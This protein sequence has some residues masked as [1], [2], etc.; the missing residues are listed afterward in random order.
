MLGPMWP[1]NIVV[2]GAGIFGVTAAD[3]LA[4][5]G[6]RLTLLERGHVPDPRAASTDL[7]RIIRMDAGRDTT[8]ASLADSCVT[9][10][11]SSAA[12][13]G[14]PVYHADG[15][16]VLSRR[17]PTPGGFVQESIRTLERMGRAVRRLDRA[18]LARSFPAWARAD[19]ADGY[20]NPRGGWVEAGAALAAW[21][22][23]AVGA[24]V[25]LREESTV[26]GLWERGGAVRGVVLASGERL[27]ADRVLITA[28]SETARLV[29][30][31]SSRLDS[32]GQ[33]VFH[34]MPVD[35]T[36]FHSRAFPPWALDIGEA[37]WYGLP[38][39]RHGVLKIAHH[40]AGVA[41]DPDD[42][43]TVPASCVER[44]RSFLESH[45]PVLNGARI[46][47]QRLC[48][49]TETTDGDFLID[50]DPEHPGLVI[51]TGGGGHGF[52]FAPQLGQIA[53][54]VIDGRPNPW[55][56]RFAWRRPA[57]GLGAARTPAP[58]A[59]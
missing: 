23:R 36:P 30:W 49:T 3:V 44:L 55:R 2:V 47:A 48:Q 4:R 18:T 39:N 1:L 6:H 41:M 37:G 56:E 26:A 5:R 51:S 58:S 34:L 46:A 10:W 35:G 50:A 29:P 40:G 33:P 42:R 9:D 7:G 28:G 59:P 57:A 22:R 31:T 19:F 25:R 17:G 45:L 14:E 13:L 52:K 32:V 8:C 16:L 15:F 12:W 20:F 27:E 53:A 38:L 21:A 54:D 43:R 11:E 24:G